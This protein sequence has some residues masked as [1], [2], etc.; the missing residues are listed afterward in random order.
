MDD[1]NGARQSDALRHAE[2]ISFDDTKPFLD[3]MKGRM[4][5]RGDSWPEEGPD[6]EYLSVGITACHWLQLCP[7]LGLHTDRLLS[8]FLTH[9][10]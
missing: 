6:G 10:H 7:S 4:A 5:C 2:C 3:H 8:L 1:A 9:I